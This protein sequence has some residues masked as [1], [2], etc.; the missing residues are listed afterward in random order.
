M[1]SILGFLIILGPLVII[2]EFGHYSF[3]KLFGVKAEIFSIGFGPRIF[4]KK[5]GETEWRVSLIPMGGYVKLMGEDTEADVS[6]AEMKRALHKQ[7]VWKR[8]FIFFGGPLFNFIFAALLFMA[9][10]AIGEPQPASYIGRVV[11]NSAAQKAGFMSG[12]HITAI[13]GKPTRLFEDV[14][15]A[16]NEHPAKPVT[17]D[18]I[19]PGSSQSLQASRVEVKPEEQDGYSVYGESTHVGEINGLLLA[20]R[21]GAIGISDPSSMAGKA[22]IKTGDELVEMNGK[23]LTT[24]EE[25]EQI[26]KALP[27]Q[28]LALKVKKAKGETLTVSL[29]R[30]SISKNLGADFG[31]YS[32]ELFVEKTVSGSPA[33]KA[34]VKAG[35]R[36]VGVGTN[37]VQS[38]FDLRDAVQRAGEN[39]G[40]VDLSWERGGKLMAFKITPTSTAGRD[41]LMKKTVQYTVGVMPMLTLVE[42]IKITERIYNPFMLAYKGTEKM[43]VLSWRNLVSIQ[44]MF[45]GDVSVKSLGGPIMIGKIAGESL[46]HGLATFLTTMAI[47]SIGLGVLNVLPVPV[48][49]GG[50]LLLL[51]IEGVR[52]KPL[53]IRQM[54]IV[55]GVG[56]SLILL[57]M[58]VVM[59]ND[60]MRLPFFD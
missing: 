49:D 58:V 15:V 53:S 6:P 23:S 57:L 11:E 46:S 54:E 26:Y 10:L 43:I 51:A 21:S 18:V 60:I 7:A 27:A 32:S 55:Q 1:L 41:P 37:Q 50:H 59:K 30:P 16:I 4:S 35:D 48:L 14:M 12:D 3:A 36:L 31:L 56:L 34:G 22:G 9:T 19:H 52:K 40:H 38:F 42:P 33:E 8:F 20:A 45:V 29:T 13:D 5:M 17:F 44:K 25:A 47:L 2:H 24:W 28:A 39:E